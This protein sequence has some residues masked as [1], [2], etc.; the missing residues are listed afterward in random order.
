M[1]YRL[2][3]SERALVDVENAFVWYQLQRIGL[4]W[5][6]VGDLEGTYKRIQ[7][8]PLAGRVVHRNVRIGR[9]RRFPYVVYYRL[10]G[11]TIEIRR[12]MHERRNPTEWQAR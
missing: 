4:G 10:N 8:V 2:A 12:C 9:L 1:I 5:E 7:A 3:P 11:H 6:F